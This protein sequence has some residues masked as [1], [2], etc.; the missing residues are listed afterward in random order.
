MV[1][2]WADASMDGIVETRWGKDGFAREAPDS[3]WTEDTLQ[4]HL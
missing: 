1:G 2:V 4:F 3:T